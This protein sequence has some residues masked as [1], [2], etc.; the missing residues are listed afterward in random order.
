MCRTV[1]DVLILYGCRSGW[2]PLSCRP[3]TVSHTGACS[4]ARQNM[5]LVCRRCT[6]GHSLAR[7]CYSSV[8]RLGTYSAVSPPCRGAPRL[9]TTAPAKR[10]SFSSR[11]A[12]L[13]LG[14]QRCGVS[15]VWAWHLIRNNSAESPHLRSHMPWRGAGSEAQGHAMISSN[16]LR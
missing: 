1:A 15:D 10:A 7:A 3:G 5:A 16:S 14:A 11:Y 9:G 6:G 12:A 13:S 8:T 4:T 2:W